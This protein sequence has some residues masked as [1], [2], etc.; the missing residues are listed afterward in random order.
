MPEAGE[1]GQIPGEVVT[2]S[3]SGSAGKQELEAAL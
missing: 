2:G 3:P 1:L